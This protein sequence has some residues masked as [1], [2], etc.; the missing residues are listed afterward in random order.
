MWQWLRVRVT[1]RSFLFSF[2]ST[3]HTRSDSLRFHF[4]LVATIILSPPPLY[5]VPPAFITVCARTHPISTMVSH[6][7]VHRRKQGP[8]ENST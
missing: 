1:S 2:A 6:S 4:L 3:L 5:L 8:Y 7:S